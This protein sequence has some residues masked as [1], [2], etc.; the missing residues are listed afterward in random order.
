MWI[1]LVSCVY[2][3]VSLEGKFGSGFAVGQTQLTSDQ[4]GRVCKSVLHIFYI[5]FY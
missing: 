2:D 4:V 5:E 3:P 1:Y